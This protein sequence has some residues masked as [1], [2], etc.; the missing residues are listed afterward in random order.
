MVRSSYP[1]Q[2]SQLP[3]ILESSIRILPK[4][5]KNHYKYIDNNI[6]IYLKQF[7]LLI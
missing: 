4:Q 6:V 7:I 1:I 3:L 5:L 2:K